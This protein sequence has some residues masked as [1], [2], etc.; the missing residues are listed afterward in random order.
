M[1]LSQTFFYN[2]L[3][4]IVASE[5]NILYDLMNFRVRFLELWL[6][7]LSMETM[8]NNLLVNGFLKYF[9]FILY[10]VQNKQYIIHTQKE[11]LYPYV[12]Q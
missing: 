11:I 10:Q 1:Q 4:K 2:F 9:S 5:R 8:E 7:M 6:V 12:L 3:I